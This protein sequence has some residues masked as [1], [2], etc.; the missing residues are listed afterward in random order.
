GNLSGRLVAAA[1]WWMVWD[2]SQET[3][4]FTLPLSGRRQGDIVQVSVAVRMPPSASGERRIRMVLEGTG[5][6]DLADVQVV[7]RGTEGK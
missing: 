4:S 3:T 5:A 6:V 1:P 2:R 7:S